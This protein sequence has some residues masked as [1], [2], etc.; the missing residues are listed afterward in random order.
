MRKLLLT[1]V[2][3]RRKYTLATGPG[4]RD[5]T[6]SQFAAA[7]TAFE[8]RVAAANR[9]VS[10]LVGTGWSGRAADDFGQGWAEVVDGIGEVQD[11]L[12]GMSKLLPQAA[13]LYANT[14]DAVA[15]DAADSASLVSRT[16][17]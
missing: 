10:G 2:L 5:P 6:G 15:R 14:D 1:L 16:E 17:G 8:T 11:A 7:I 13:A 12:A 4:R 9:A 3:G